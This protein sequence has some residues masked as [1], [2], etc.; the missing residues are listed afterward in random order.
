MSQVLYRQIRQL[1]DAADHVLLLT[2]ERIDGDTLGSTLGMAHVLEA[3]EKR[4]SVYSPKELPTMFAFM[5]GQEKI[6]R[7]SSVFLDDSIDLVMIFDCSDG[8]YISERDK[9]PSMKHRVPLVVVDHHRTNPRYGTVN[10]IEED[11]ASTA[12]VVWRF[13][14][15]QDLP[16]TR[17]AA[18]CILTGIC[19]DTNAFSTSTT[20]AACMDAAHE[21]SRYG[22]RLQEIVRETMMNK[23]VETLRLWGLAFE[24]LHD[25][26][27]F[28]A[29]CTA[30]TQKDLKALNVTT[31]DTKHMIN[32]LNAMLDDVDVILVLKETDDGA[33]K[34]SLRAHRRDVAKMAAKFG[35][36]GHR[37]AAGFKIENARLVEK[38]GAWFIDVVVENEGAPPRKS[39]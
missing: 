23:S 18:Q 1:I 26:P 12:D 2:D 36:G 3:M 33:V 20:T 39:T 15:A 8:A 11:A 16:M 9:V 37:R 35:G 30:L 27:E 22:A 19:H 5:P 28:D 31:A 21:L 14:Q 13:V 4:V 32:F 17:E 6:L 29:V 38:D 25:N 24:R 10:M 34:G 7:D